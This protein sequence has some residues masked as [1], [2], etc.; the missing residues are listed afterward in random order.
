MLGAKAISYHLVINSWWYHFIG[1]MLT[2][3][4]TTLYVVP[5]FVALQ[6][7]V[8]CDSACVIWLCLCG[9]CYTASRLC[10]ACCM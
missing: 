2:G 10:G 9:S 4:I 8:V 3:Y 6:V 5:A 7:L 1:L